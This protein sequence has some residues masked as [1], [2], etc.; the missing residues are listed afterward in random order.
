MV[1]NDNNNNGDR[2]APFPRRAV[3]AMPGSGQALLI[4][5]KPDSRVQ[6]RAASD[7]TIERIFDAFFSTTTNAMGM[8][9]AICGAIVETHG[10]TLSASAG[11][12][13][14]AVLQVVLPGSR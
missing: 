7:S 3:G 12:P 1:K 5:A 9:L 11:V 4:S 2:R 10:G 14:G 8:G 6:Q 13:H